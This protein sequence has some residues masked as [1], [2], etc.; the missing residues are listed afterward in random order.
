MEGSGV[1]AQRNGIRQTSGK[2]SRGNRAQDQDREM[3]KG[4]SHLGLVL[5]M[6]R[7]QT[8]CFLPRTA[9]Q[10]ILQS[11]KWDKGMKGQGR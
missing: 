9:L 6:G 4:N 3:G 7:Q 1:T 8:Q 5:L 11:Q 2:E 10:S